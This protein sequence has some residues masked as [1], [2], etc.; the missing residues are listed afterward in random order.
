[1]EYQIQVSK[2]SEKDLAKARCYYKIKGIE[3]N[4]LDDFITQ[5]NYLKSN[6]L[7]FQTRYKNVRKIHFN[8]FKYSIHYIIENQIVFILRILSHREEYGE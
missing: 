5:I 6:P 7:L 2:E 8:N 3:E 4:F 1:M